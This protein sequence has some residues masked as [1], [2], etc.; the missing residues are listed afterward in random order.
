MQY[1]KPLTTPMTTCLKLLAYGGHPIQDPQLYR[2]VVGT[3]I[4]ICNDN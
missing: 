4:T 1:A 2:S 3:L